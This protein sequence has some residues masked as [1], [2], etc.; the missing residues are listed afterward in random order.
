MPVSTVF[1]NLQDMSI[2]E[3]VEEFG[4]TRE[5]MEAVLQC[6]SDCGSLPIQTLAATLVLPTGN[7]T[8]HQR[9]PP[10][11]AFFPLVVGE[12]LDVGA[13]VTHHE[14]LPVGLWRIR[15]SNLVLETHPGTREGD[16]FAIER[17]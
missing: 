5:Q 8:G 2:D 10:R 1:E 3:L 11:G 16:R 12:L 15:I 9:L 14:N 6:R 13:V 7:S 4:V 17:P